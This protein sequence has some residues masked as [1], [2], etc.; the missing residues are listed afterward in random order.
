[1]PGIPS[2]L[3]VPLR[4]T[5]VD[6][7]SFDSN[8]EVGY[9]FAHE[10]LIPWRNRVPEASSVMKR[11]DG[12]INFLMDKRRIETQTSALVLLLGVL[13]DRTDQSDVCYERLANLTVELDAVL[14]T[15]ASPTRSIR[16]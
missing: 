11:V 8:E 16:L 7:G 3:Y 13:R 14:Q 12:I 1:M 9:L 15:S 10:L 5:L 6:C 4:Q 2:R